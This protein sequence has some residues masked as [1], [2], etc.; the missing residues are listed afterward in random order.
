MGKP[1]TYNHEGHNLHLLH[2]LSHRPL[3][4]AR[5]GQNI[6]QEREQEGEDVG[7]PLER[8]VKNARRQF[9]FLTLASVSVTVSFLGLALISFLSF[10]LESQGNGTQR[11]HT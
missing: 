6:V 5:M 11:Q 8:R 9:P 3:T 1:L 7:P 4:R 2:S 10:P